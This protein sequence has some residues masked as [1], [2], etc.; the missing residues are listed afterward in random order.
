MRD[1]ITPSG[2]EGATIELTLLSRDKKDH[3]VSSI[4]MIK[5]YLRS[6]QIF[7]SVLSVVLTIGTV[8]TDAVVPAD[9][10]LR[11]GLPHLA[12]FAAFSA[13][14]NSKSG[15]TVCFMV[16]NWQLP[17]GGG[18]LSKLCGTVGMARKAVPGPNEC[19]AAHA[20]TVCLSESIK[21]FV[22]TE[23]SRLCLPNQRPR[24]SVHATR[25]FPSHKKLLWRWP[26]LT[27]MNIS[28][29]INTFCLGPLSSFG[30]RAGRL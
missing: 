10:W 20:R 12:T 9:A 23:P 28:L 19:P 13:A 14:S 16:W 11:R 30:K 2:R 4:F 21:G 3:E 26:T 5:P 8:L 27:I 7:E 24:K 6:L 22:S 25:K 18:P 29:P 1:A 15:T 17:F